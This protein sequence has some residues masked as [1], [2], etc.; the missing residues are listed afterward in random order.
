[1]VTARA[2]GLTRRKRRAMGAAQNDRMTLSKMMRSWPS[3]SLPRVAKILALG[4]AGLALAGCQTWPGQPPL[5]LSQK[6][7]Q[8][9]MMGIDGTDAA[10]AAGARQE[11]LEGKAGSRQA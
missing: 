7:V 9:V 3:P 6:A 11:P 5:T 10:F 8:M 4:L 2:G 1:M